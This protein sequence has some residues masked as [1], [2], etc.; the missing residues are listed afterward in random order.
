MKFNNYQD[1]SNKNKY[2]S[3]AQELFEPENFELGEG[4][5]NFPSVGS[6]GKKP[7]PGVHLKSIESRDDL[8]QNSWP[9]SIFLL[10]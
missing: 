8:M 1:Y 5:E 9:K 10:L 4:C 3:M 2:T 7:A 6:Y